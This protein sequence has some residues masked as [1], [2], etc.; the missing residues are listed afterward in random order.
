MSVVITVLD[1]E[2]VVQVSDTR[3]TSF[4]DQSVMSETTRKTLVVP[5]GE[6][7]VRCGLGRFRR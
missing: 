2:K 3:V 1:R 7:K 6:S 4:A 5:R